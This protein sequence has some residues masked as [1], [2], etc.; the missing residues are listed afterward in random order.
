MIKIYSIRQILKLKREM[1]VEKIIEESDGFS[2][3]FPEHKHKIV[4]YLQ[5][6]DI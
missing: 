3:V 2:E 1:E 5:K 6:G 4:E